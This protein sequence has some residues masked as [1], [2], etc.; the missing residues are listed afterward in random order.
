[1]RSCIRLSVIVTCVTFL[2]LSTWAGRPTGSTRTIE[3]LSQ[4]LASPN[5]H[6][7]R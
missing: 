6:T 5:A 1:M 3:E 7:R 4:Q 2:P